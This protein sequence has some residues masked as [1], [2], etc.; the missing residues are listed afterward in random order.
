MFN[1]ESC[2]RTTNPGEACKQVVVEWRKKAYQAQE[3]R[4]KDAFGVAKMG[5]G[6]SGEGFEAAR[7]IKACPACAPTCG[8]AR[9]E[10]ARRERTEFPTFPTG[11]ST[12]RKDRDFRPRQ[13]VAA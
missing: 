9:P 11:L 3:V 5:F 12:G 4:K 6:R 13:A 1:C 8:A 7:V 2:G 10:T